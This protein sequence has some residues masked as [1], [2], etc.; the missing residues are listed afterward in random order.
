MAEDLQPDPDLPES[1][2]QYFRPN[3]VILTIRHPQTLHADP[4]LTLLKSVEWLRGIILES[5]VVRTFSPDEADV[6]S[7]SIITAGVADGILV[8]LLVRLFNRSVEGQ[9]IDIPS[10]DH[11]PVTLVS[12][13]PDWL[14]GGGTHQIVGGGPGGVP[15]SVAA[16]AV[17]SPWQFS[18]LQTDGTMQ[19][20][21]NEGT[22]GNGVMVVLLDTAPSVHILAA[23]SHN[24][25]SPP[26]LVDHPIVQSL[27]A[28]ATAAIP[29]KLH[30]HPLSYEILQPLAEYSLTGQRY[31]MPDHGLFVAGIVNAIAPGADL[32]LVEALSPHCVGSLDSIVAALY[33]AFTVLRNPLTPLIVNCSATL[34]AW[35]ATHEMGGLPAQLQGPLGIAFVNGGLDGLCALL[36]F[37]AITIVAAAG[38]DSSVA[39]RRGPAYPAA[40]NSVISVGALAPDPAP[41]VGTVYPPANY[42]NMPNTNTKDGFMVLGGTPAV[43]IMGA[44][45]G[46]VLHP[47][48][49]NN[50]DTQGYRPNG[51]GWARWAGTSFAAP[52]ISGLCARLA[53]GIPLFG[54][55]AG[56]E[57][58]LVNLATGTVASVPVDGSAV[59]A[60][61]AIHALAVT[62][63]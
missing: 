61:T 39:V 36:R 25:E 18:M 21:I 52:I 45:I 56:I 14:A 37:S 33:H 11:S 31:L 9:P 47:G 3:R 28:P 63:P 43:G 55:P 23:A 26:K 27:L 7:L 5:A 8:E 34:G 22:N 4:L 40:Y 19:S 32:H 20:P 57:A 41:V 38:N 60:P 58:A 17:G 51:T 49:I 2:R 10:A 12:A 62:Q 42:T 1:A 35:T 29:G 6:P 24:W 48:Y 44:Y 54:R 30:V 13:S 59:A 50:P 53:T 46:D 16:P 15:V